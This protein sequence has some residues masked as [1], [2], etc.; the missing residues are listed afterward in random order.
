MSG[1]SVAEWIAGSYK[2]LSDRIQELHDVIEDGDEERRYQAWDELDEMPLAVDK[3]I[4]LQFCFTFGGPNVFVTATYSDGATD[5]FKVL[6]KV[7]FEAVWGSETLRR[8]CGPS[9]PIWAYCEDW[10]DRILD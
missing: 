10:A 5:S 9:D 1:D 3:K 6:E 4:V 2:S 8:T 7:E